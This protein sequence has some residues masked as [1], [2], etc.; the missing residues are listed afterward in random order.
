VRPDA[1]IVLDGVSKR[2][3]RARGRR[4]LKELALDPTG[5]LRGEEFWALRDV[6]LKVARGSTTGV[7]GAN[8]A[9]KSTLLRLV[10]GLGKPT[11]GSVSRPRDVAAMLTLGDTFDPLL[12]GRENAVTAG[13]LAGFRR[14]DV[15]AQLGDVVAFA[16]LEHVFDHPLRTYSDGMRIRLA[17]A[18]AVAAEPDALVI[19]EV[20][21]VGDLRF[22]E[23]CF[24]R[25]EELQARG[26]TILLASH[27]DGLV[28]RL[29]SRV[30]W[31]DQGRVRA[32]G[33]PE[34]VLETY[35]GAMRAETE[36]RVAASGGAAPGGDGD[37]VGTL[38]VEIA[39]VRVLPATIEA[40]S[41]E[42][43]IRLEIDLVP[44]VPVEQ[45]VV[46]V[47]L[48][49]EGDYARMLDLSTEA[50]DTALGVLDGPRTLVLELDR[51][52]LPSGAYRFD[53]GVFEQGWGYIYDYRWH[54]Y[55]L[56]VGGGG[57]GSDVRSRWSL[58]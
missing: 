53:V 58:A 12:T 15:L 4:T 13:I 10:A 30:V 6:S 49:R 32:H 51:V 23:K 27:D 5:R 45:P 2:F 40:D 36:R 29:C 37:R 22:Q 8:G 52:A 48:H 56:T 44:R 35:A 33:E 50:D 43:R 21:S 20:L 34:D 31:I 57:D 39:D 47:S 55:P 9:G 16:E 26:T 17:F 7:V 3:T 1:A 11:T 14:R 28:R 38:E 19:D 46:S 41:E 18:V 54:A 24:D 42:A 25:L